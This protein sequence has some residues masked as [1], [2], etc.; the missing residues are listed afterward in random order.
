MKLK[1]RPALLA[2]SIS[3]LTALLAG[4]QPLPA[5]QTN[6]P[7]PTEKK[8]VFIFDGGNPIDLVLAIEKHS[9]ARRR[10]I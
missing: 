8:K 4:S 5:Q 10:R 6:E 9:R 3:C 7:P 1:L 2:L